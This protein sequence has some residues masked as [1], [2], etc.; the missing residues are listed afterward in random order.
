VVQEDSLLLV[1]GQQKIINTL[2]FTKVDDH[3]Y[4]LPGILSR[5]KQL[6]PALLKAFSTA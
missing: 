4:R 6:L 1:A 2:S 5:K 3:L